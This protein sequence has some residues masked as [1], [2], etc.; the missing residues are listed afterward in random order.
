VKLIYLVLA[1]IAMPFSGFSSTVTYDVNNVTFDDGSVAN[2][3]FVVDT[4]TS[5]LVVFD[6]LLSPPL[7]ANTTGCDPSTCPGYDYFLDS[8]GA[9]S[10]VAPPGLGPEDLELV[11]SEHLYLFFPTSIFTTVGPVPVLDTSSVGYTQG[12]VFITYAVSGSVEQASAPEP[13]A[14]L[15]ALGGLFT[16]FLGSSSIIRPLRRAHGKA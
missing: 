15:L 4:S 9:N 7:T 13:S 10:L 16:M 14:W 5:Q 8:S 1:L 12:Q 2:G 6:I 11:G 3:T